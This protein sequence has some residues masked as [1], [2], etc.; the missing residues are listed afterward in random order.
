MGFYV[1]CHA[2]KGCA[3]QINKLWKSQFKGFLI[4]TPYRIKKEI[5]A[6]NKRGNGVY[7]ESVKDWNTCFPIMSTNRGQVFLRAFGYSEEKKSVFMKESDNLKAK[8]QFLL[9]NRF[10]FKKITG[11]QD[12]V[13]ALGMDIE[14]EY[15]ENGRNHKYERPTFD[16]LEQ[17][18]DCPLFKACLAKD[19]PEMWQLVLSFK[20][21]G[22][23][24][25]LWSKLRHKTV[26]FCGDTLWQRWV[27][28]KNAMLQRKPE[29]FGK[30]FPDNFFTL[31]TLL[32][33]S[34][35]QFNTLTNC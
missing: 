1:N 10:L 4:Y 26:D 17:H 33:T 32:C 3:G 16:K 19:D 25:N 12:A 35:E 22:M 18:H 29:L 28:Y 15:I 20:K 11:L 9:D 27:R 2:K 8:I 34:Q 30:A 5:E 6:H 7:L 23:T 21:N 14:A 31:H 24:E 13:E